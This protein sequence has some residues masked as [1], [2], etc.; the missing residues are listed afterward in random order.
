MRAGRGERGRIRRDGGAARASAA[1]SRRRGC[2]Q[3]ATG[4]TCM[5]YPHG[6]H[7]CGSGPFGMP[8]P[9]ART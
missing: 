8:A 5:S 7:L 9:I 3:A 4:A 1:P 6:R 2:P